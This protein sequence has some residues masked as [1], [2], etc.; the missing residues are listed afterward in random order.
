MTSWAWFAA[1][2]GAAMCL[3]SPSAASAVE[4]PAPVGDQTFKAQAQLGIQFFP[5]AAAHLVGSGLAYGV[6]IGWKPSPLWGLELG[7][8]GANYE[9]SEDLIGPAVTIVENGAGLLLRFGPRLGIFEPYV[10][11]GGAFSIVTVRSND[12]GIKHEIEDDTLI[13]VPFAVGLDVHLQPSD[14]PLT[15]TH[16]VLGVR[17]AYKLVFFDDFLSVSQRGADQM[18]ATFLI[19]VG[20]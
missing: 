6:A 7:Y 14:A 5:G 17:G 19:G 12:P 20:F 9:T 11:A 8:Q 1:S 16:V 3:A 13:K 10:M 15:A 4:A 2:L 18:E